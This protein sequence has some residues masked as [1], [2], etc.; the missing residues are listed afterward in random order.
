M[1]GK[2]LYGFYESGGANI[3]TPW[4]HLTDDA[5]ARW[6]YVADQVEEWLLEE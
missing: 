2:T 5:R 6:E 1:D 3:L 4:E